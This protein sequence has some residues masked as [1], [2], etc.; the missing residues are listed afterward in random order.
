MQ[1]QTHHDE[2]KKKKYLPWCLVTRAQPRV[3]WS[4]A[5]RRDDRSELMRAGLTRCSSSPFMVR[6]KIPPLFSNVHMDMMV[7]AIA[8]NR[9]GGL[10]F[11]V[12]GPFALA[13]LFC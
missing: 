7:V 1:E 4:L 8:V 3:D 6:R 9:R 5:W 12:F 10:A 2:G 11:F 13:S